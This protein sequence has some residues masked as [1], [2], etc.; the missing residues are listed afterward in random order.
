MLHAQENLTSFDLYSGENII[1]ESFRVSAPV[2]DVLNA[3][4]ALACDFP[5]RAVA[6]PLHIF[7]DASFQQNLSEFLEQSSTEAFDQFAARAFKGGESI[8]ETRDC[9]D[10]S[11]VNDMLMSLLEGL[12]KSTTVSQI[13]KRV[14]DDVVLDSSEVPWRRS[15]YWLVLRV[16]VGR[17]LSSM[18]GDEGTGRVCYK[19]LICVVLGYL[20]RECVG[21]LQ[22]EM[23]LILQAKLCRR[24]AKLESEQRAAPGSL[25]LLY[26]SLFS[27]TKTFFEFTIEA[28]KRDVGVQWEKHKASIVRQIPLLPGRVSNNDLALKLPQSGPYL[29]SLLSNA[30]SIMNREVRRNVPS[31]NEGTISQV[32]RLTS[33]YTDLIN[34]EAGTRS[35]VEPPSKPP[36]NICI[37]LSITINGFLKKAGTAYTDNPLLMSRYL[38][39][40]FE[41]WV[42]M[43]RAATTACPLLKKYHPVFVPRSLDVLC[44][45]TMEEM[46]RLARV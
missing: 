39:R 14:R 26:D 46:E 18:S 16:A 32:N 24:L 9:P 36:E 2:R 28:V 23:T 3:N 19:F 22:P 1:F 12:G 11:L 37:E 41:L 29:R 8:A 13:R 6:V 27:A 43:D 38:L 10:P 31:L 42:D 20:L 34:Y 21:S 33:R 30:S 17:Y 45:L 15:P 25:P 40:L 35:S 5:G 4:H 7:N 44:L